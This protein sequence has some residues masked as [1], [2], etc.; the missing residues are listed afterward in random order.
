MK[1]AVWLCASDVDAVD[2]VMYQKIYTYVL[3]DGCFVKLGP[4]TDQS[5]RFCNRHL[6]AKPLE[7]ILTKTPP[8][9]HCVPIRGID[10][11][12]PFTMC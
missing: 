9:R 5:Q 6:A 7:T 11:R 10:L 3:H 4:G 8:L 1:P 12:C 2:C